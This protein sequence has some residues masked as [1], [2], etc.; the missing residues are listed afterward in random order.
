MDDAR[1]GR[2]QVFKRKLK[3]KLRYVWF[4]NE[5]EKLKHYFDSKQ[6]LDLLRTDPSLHL[7]CIRPYLWAGLNANQRLMAQM[8]FFDWLLSVYSSHQIAHFYKMNHIT[9]CEFP[10]KDR[11][12]GVQIRPARGLGREGEIAIFLC[13]DDHALMKASFTVLPLSLLGVAGDGHAMV[14]GAFQGEKQ[15]L[16]RI[17]ETTQL[18]ER[19]KPAHLLFNVLQS[20][21]QVW[22]LQTIVGVSDSTHAYASYKRTL[23]KRVKTNYDAIWQELGGEQLRNRPHWVLPRNWQPKPEAEVESKKRAAYKRRNVLRQSFM[24]ACTEAA[25]HLFNNIQC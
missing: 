2:M 9:L 24:N 17:K 11:R 21:A 10:V 6:L 22:Q 16:D 7:K 19:I 12:L 1:G 15:S 5:L 13:L 20:F 4:R 25:P 14:V 23:A 18:M 3:F 8:A